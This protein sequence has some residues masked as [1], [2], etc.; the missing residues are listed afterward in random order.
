MLFFPYQWEKSFGVKLLE[1]GYDIQI[2][3]KDE[4]LTLTTQGVTFYPLD[5]VLDTY[6][7]K[8]SLWNVAP[9]DPK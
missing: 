8:V 7:G 3:S 9:K 6:E 5:N 2:L 4:L 1:R